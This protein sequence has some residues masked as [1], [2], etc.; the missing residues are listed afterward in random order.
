MRNQFFYTRTI[1]TEEE[2]TITETSY[3][4]SFSLDFVIRTVTLPTG[5]LIVLLNDLH[6]Q[7]QQ[8][9]II[10]QTTGEVESYKES[11]INV[12]S[13]ISLS[14]E[15]SKRFFALTNVEVISAIYKNETP[16]DWAKNSTS[17]AIPSITVVTE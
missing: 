1:K 3:R 6:E 15:D 2:G 16:I 12:Q 5:E 11:R 10:N 17:G 8:V 14:I 7:V 9:P 13:E 4:D